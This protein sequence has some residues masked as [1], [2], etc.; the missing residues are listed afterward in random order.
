MGNMQNNLK[1]WQGGRLLFGHDI[2]LPDERQV[3]HITS[4]LFPD[5]GCALLSAKNGDVKHRA[6]EQLKEGIIDVVSLVLTKEP[7]L[8][9]LLVLQQLDIIDTDGAL[10]VFNRLVELSGGKID[11]AEK[12]LDCYCCDVTGNDFCDSDH[13]CTSDRS[14]PGSTGLDI[15][16]ILAA[17][18]YKRPKCPSLTNL[19]EE[20]LSFRRNF[21]RRCGDL[22]FLDSCRRSPLR[23]VDALS[24]EGC[25]FLLGNWLLSLGM[26]DVSFFVTF[27]RVAP[28]NEASARKSL[29]H[30]SVVS[31]TRTSSLQTDGEHG[32]VCV[33]APGSSS[34]ACRRTNRYAYSVK[35][36]DCDPKPARKLRGREK[37][38]ALVEHFQSTK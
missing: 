8:R 29:S 14:N 15:E 30:S 34:R 9:R 2:D 33:K 36:V 32:E 22:D 38:E 7:F 16:Q 10:A 23:C 6:E 35:V 3:F 27:R 26:C 1:V 20:I 4:C 11:E 18:P 28:D 24:K 31:E 19:L 37:S 5:A 12:D 17:S 25:L 21:G 13:Q